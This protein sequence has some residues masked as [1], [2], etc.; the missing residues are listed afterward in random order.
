MCPF[1][2]GKQSGAPAAALYPRQLADIKALA[3]IL[4]I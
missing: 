4:N 2:H 3:V 1:S